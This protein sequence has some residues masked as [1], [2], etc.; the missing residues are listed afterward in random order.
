MALVGGTE[1]M[2][3]AIAC[4]L[5]ALSFS[6][7]T[8]A[9]FAVVA[10]I[11]LA[12]A[13]EPISKK[14]ERAVLLFSVSAIIAR[15]II[16][17]F[18]GKEN[19]AIPLLIAAIVFLLTKGGLLERISA[20]LLEKAGLALPLAISAA[21]L[22]SGGIFSSPDAPI[23]TD[24]P[25]HYFRSLA[26]QESGGM[27]FSYDASFGAGI[28]DGL[29]QPQGA[30]SLFAGLAGALSTEKAPLPVSSAFI[31]RATVLI[32]FL[33]PIAGIYI[34]A[35]T[36]GNSKAFSSSSALLWL[37]FPHS[38]FLHGLYSTY[39]SLG[40]GLFGLAFIAKVSI[41]KEK[42]SRARL[43]SASLL[44]GS[45]ILLHILTGAQ[46]LFFSIVAI[47]LFSGLRAKEKLVSSLAVFFT[48]VGI[49]FLWI[50]PAT[51]ASEEFSFSNIRLLFPYY[52]EFDSLIFTRFVAPFPEL[53]VGALIGAILTAGA[54]FLGKKAPFKGILGKAGFPGLLIL[55]TSVAL[56]TSLIAI[57][58]FP[59]TFN[60]LII[61]RSAM[62]IRAASCIVVPAILYFLGRN[63]GIFV[64]A[65]KAIVVGSALFLIVCLA[66]FYSGN[67]WAFRQ[68]TGSTAGE[69]FNFLES[70]SKGSDG[71]LFSARVSD[72]LSLSS[73]WVRENAPYPGGRVFYEDTHLPL[74]GGHASA[75]VPIISGRQVI[76]GP[77]P[78]ATY[79]GEKTD[80]FEGSVF[81]KQLSDYSPEEL[82]EKFSA[83]GITYAIVR[84]DEME[85]KLNRP[86]LAEFG[87]LS[88]KSVKGD[89]NGT[90]FE[91][92]SAFEVT[93]PL[94]GNSK[95]K[96]FKGVY[97]IDLDSGENVNFSVDPESRFILVGRPGRFLVKY[98]PP[99]E[100]KA[101][102]VIISISGCLMFLSLSKSFHSQKGNKH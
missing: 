44:L 38:E 9:G 81:G 98:D 51:L 84:T 82:E 13:W 55:T 20:S 65:G 29:V 88:I 62:I 1:R 102:P 68:M 5:L 89:S 50:A 72:Q 28:I 19:V 92:S 41:S 64:R 26:S 90:I 35:R 14:P 40:I 78:S 71:P 11:L 21:I 93:T 32:S 61:D 49:A 18:Q 27:M 23:L 83:L 3:L 45:S 48:S 63:N 31:F 42:L 74:F 94:G 58:A 24:Y 101:I 2:R 96:H 7:F 54:I 10:T 79:S 8:L 100:R 66:L 59:E 70:D 22:F 67:S 91:G 60:Q 52:F 56:G 16:L 25:I 87:N 36:L 30:F 37:A 12:I 69:W 99:I 33:L 46:M 34:L 6:S 4:A 47:G 39:A 85:K 17:P 80:V 95:M 53:A 77:I 76:G 73:R 75:F 15:I 86:S 43:F 57:G 97:L